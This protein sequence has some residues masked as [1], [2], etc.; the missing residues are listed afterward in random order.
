MAR[1]LRPLARVAFSQ[2]RVASGPA[3]NRCAPSNR[4]PARVCAARKTA[5]TVRRAGKLRGS[6]GKSRRAMSMEGLASWLAV[7]VGAPG[8]A[9]LIRAK[10]VGERSCHVLEA[11]LEFAS[12]RAGR[13]PGALFLLSGFRRAHRQ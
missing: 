1:K 11:M 4:P 2:N 5:R 12:L 9:A 7:I 3:S 6:G 13:P 8:A 10:P